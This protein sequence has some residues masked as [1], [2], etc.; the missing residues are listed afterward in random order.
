LAL[1][2]SVLTDYTATHCIRYRFI[3]HT[4]QN[5]HSRSGEAERPRRGDG[6]QGEEGDAPGDDVAGDVAGG[7]GDAAQQQQQQQDRSERDRPRS[8]GETP[9]LQNDRRGG[10]EGGEHGESIAVLATFHS[11]QYHDF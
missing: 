11:F 6:G 5:D 10:A 8:R 9:D 4:Q 7:G 1:L 2:I 3:T